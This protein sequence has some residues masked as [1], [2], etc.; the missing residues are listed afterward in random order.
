MDTSSMTSICKFSNLARSGLKLCSLS[1]LYGIGMY[2]FKENA[3]WIV[4]PPILNAAVPVNA[5]N[6]IVVSS[7]SEQIF[8][9]S[10]E[11]S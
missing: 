3:W 10:L 2:L 8:C 7:G 4:Q 9:K 1:G 6:N 5:V 11:A